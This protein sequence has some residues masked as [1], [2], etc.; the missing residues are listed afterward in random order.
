MGVGFGLKE[1]VSNFVS[2]IWLLFEGALKPGDIVN[3]GG[4]VGEVKS[5]GIRAATVRVLRDGTEKIL[6]NQTFFTTEVT[7]YTG[8]DLLVSW[9]VM[10]GVSY[11]CNPK[12]VLDILLQI[13]DQHPSVLQD[14]PPLAFFLEFGESSLNFELKFWAQHAQTNHRPGGDQ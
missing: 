5:L 13:A 12:T 4:E 10:V 14:P 3:V 6:P 1:V 2:G 9:S 11:N 8:S 7:T